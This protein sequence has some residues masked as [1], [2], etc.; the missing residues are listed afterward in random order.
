MDTE[1]RMVA[2]DGTDALA[3]VI[4][5]PNPD[6]APENPIVAEAAA[7]G[8]SRRA[9]A[10]VLRSVADQFDP[11]GALKRTPAKPAPS[12]AHRRDASE[13]ATLRR[14]VGLHITAAALLG[15]KATAGAAAAA[16]DE[17]LD[18][19]GIDLGDRADRPTTV[20]RCPERLLWIVGSD[21]HAE[22]VTSAAEWIH[23]NW[24]REPLFPRQVDRRE[25]CDSCWRAAAFAV[26]GVVLAGY[27]RADSPTS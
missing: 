8:L 18:I 26:K 9:A 24:H 16:L 14:I 27:A 19:H 10:H 13:L 21:Q 6:G 7:H 12:A 1:T 23:A 5:R 20:A 11:A 15:D 17:E 3:Y 22:A 25:V 4:I 2:V